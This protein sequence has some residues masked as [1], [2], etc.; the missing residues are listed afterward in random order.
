[1]SAKDSGIGPRSAISQASSRSERNT[2]CVPST[3]KRN[4]TVT[5]Q[6]PCSA[7][8]E[9]G[10]NEP[11]GGLAR[12]L[13]RVPAGEI[14][15]AKVA[16]C[17][18][19]SSRALRVAVVLVSAPVMSATPVSRKRRLRKLVFA[20]VV[21]AI[22]L[23]LAE[24]AMRAIAWATGR[25]RCMTYDESLGWRMMANV[26]RRDAD[27]CRDRPGTTNSHGWRDAEHG[28]ARRPGVRRLLA[29]GDSGTFGPGVDQ[30]ER[31]TEYLEDDATEV[32]NIGVCAWGTDQE[33]LAYEAEGHAYRADVVL[34]LVTICNDLEDI[35]SSRKAGWS[36]P[37]FTL[38]PDGLVLH[39][40]PASWSVQLRSVSYFAEALLQLFERDRPSAAV[41]P[42]WREAD[43]LP[44]FRALVR[45]L[46]AAVRHDGA[47]LLVVMERPAD[48]DPPEIARNGLRVLEALAQDGIQVLDLRLGFDMPPAQRHELNLPDGHWSAKANRMAADE[49]RAE[50]RRLGW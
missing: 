4:G 24:G 33:V 22:A 49:I 35:K 16:R 42:E 44:L 34:L 17:P 41:A 30:G 14:V 38:E 20:F 39:R 13:T 8:T 36:K 5:P 28:F 27:W 21:L 3:R 12:A 11:F 2:C 18:E 37:Y 47:E 7:F 6:Q 43:S 46:A 10:R 50:L 45:R 26:V 32:I 19:C 40:P 25:E 1:M 48:G 31:F 9:N 15:P 29:L 23:L